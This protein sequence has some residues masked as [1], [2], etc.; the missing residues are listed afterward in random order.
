MGRHHPGK[1]AGGGGGANGALVALTQ[2]V[3]RSK[4][5]DPMCRPRPSWIA[6]LALAAAIGGCG[7]STTKKNGGFPS[8]DGGFQG[9]GGKVGGT[10]G[11]GGGAGSGATGGSSGGGQGGGA[12]Q[13]EAGGFPSDAGQASG[14]TTGSDAA[15]SAPDAPPGPQPPDA[16]PDPPCRVDISAVA[17]GRLDGLPTGSRLRVQATAAGRLAPR[18]E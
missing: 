5:P 8:A 17:P 4:P 7:G 12:P 2:S 15:G 11:Q 16:M 18:S 9:T 1:R 3:L 10:G 13:A 14:G 6:V